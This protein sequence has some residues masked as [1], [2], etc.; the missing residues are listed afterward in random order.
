M[1]T[2]VSG[3]SCCEKLKDLS[4]LYIVLG[5]VVNAVACLSKL[6]LQLCVGYAADYVTFY[7][8]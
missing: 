7:V 6:C 2:D 4:F 5:V 3:K 8:M 1:K